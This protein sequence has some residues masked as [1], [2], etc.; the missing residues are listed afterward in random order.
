MPKEDKVA[1]MLREDLADTRTMWVK[2]AGG[3]TAEARHRVESDFLADVNHEGER[4]DFHSLRHTCGAWLA[5]AG[6]HPKAVQTVMRHSSITLTM[7]TYGHLFPGQEAETVARFPD[8]IEAGGERADGKESAHGLH[9]ILH[10]PETPTGHGMSSH[11]NEEDGVI[12][13]EGSPKSSGDS[14]L[15]HPL[16]PNVSNGRRRIRTSEGVRQ[17][18]YSLPPL[19]TWVSA[20]REPRIVAKRPA[21]SNPP[22]HGLA[23]ACPGHILPAMTQLAVSIMVDALDSAHAQAAVAAERGADLVE[24]RIDTFTDRPD[25]VAK[26]VTSSP[27]PC[28]VTCR[29]SWEGGHHEGNDADR[30]ALFAAACEAGATY[31]DVELVAY[32]REPAWRGLAERYAPH[33]GL[34]LSS[35]DF[36]QRPAD[37]YRRVEKMVAANVCRVIKLAWMAR[38]LRDNLQAMELIAAQHKPTIALCMGKAGQPS[39]VLAKKFGALLTFAGLDDEAV[40][41]PGQVGVAT[42][43]GRY[44]WDAQQPSTAVYGVIGWPVAHSMSPAI[45]NAGFDAVGHD[46]VHLPMP[47]PPEYEHFKATVGAWLES[48]PLNFRGASVTLPHKENL[49][50]FVDEAGGEVEPLAR[51]IGA[52]NTLT[53]RDDGALYASNTD[54]A[55]ALDALCNKM[56]IGREGLKDKTVGVIGAGGAARAIVAGLAHYGA[57]VTIYNRTAERARRLAGSFDAEIETAPLAALASSKCAVYINCTPIG[58]HPEVN[59]TPMPELPASLGE[60]AVV[61]DTI[62]NPAE[63]LLL[64]EARAAGATTLSGGAMFVGQAAAQFELWTGEPAPLSVFEG[65]MRQRLG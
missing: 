62:Y 35:H 32:E 4:L 3:D 23:S 37:L 54:H 8:M 28:I 61:F 56:R 18:I 64:R 1:A 46:G 21:A 14:G 44:R 11:A 65:V 40:T 63:T 45:H 13:R 36:E 20:L 33:T 31:I 29:P 22:I 52:A 39:R 7:D 2:A 34:I 50:R 12:H 24:Y 9:Q 49:I 10:L 48:K 47:I 16:S 19:A 27:L 26:L 5:K 38:S 60:Q 53:V 43:K 30:L 42:L 15:C 58:M 51:T 57:A 6:A 25:E 17:Q 55:G 59:Q 41:A